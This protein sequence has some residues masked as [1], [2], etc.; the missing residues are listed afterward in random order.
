MRRA[1]AASATEPDASPTPRP[2]RL[3]E[4]AA[5]FRM[6]R[7]RRIDLES[8]SLVAEETAGWPDLVH[9]VATSIDAADDESLDAELPDALA[10]DVAAPWFEAMLGELDDGTVR[11]LGRCAALPAV[12]TGLATALAGRPDASSLASALEAGAV[13]H[14]QT[15]DGRRTLA[16]MLRR[17]LL[18]RMGVPEREEIARAAGRR[19]LAEGAAD[20]A[21]CALAA[22][23]CWHDLADLLATVPESRTRPG[24][25]VYAAPPQVVRTMPPIAAAAEQAEADGRAV[26]ESNAR[27]PT[28]AAPIGHR[29]APLAAALRRLRRGDVVGAVPS[30]R[31]AVRSSLAARERLTARLALLVIRA[32]LARREDLLDACCVLERDALADGLGGLARL[33]RGAI[34]ALCGPDG[35]RR[36]ATRDVID[37]FEQHGDATGAAIVEGLAVLSALRAGRAEVGQT[38]AFAEQCERSMQRE[39]A[40]WARAASAM[41]GAANGDD[42]LDRLM[43]S[44]ESAA[45]EAG[46]SG[47]RAFLEAAL[48]LSGAAGSAGHVASARRIA[49]ETGLPRL[50][51][52]SGLPA[53][54]RPERVSARPVG[55][56]LVHVR[57]RTHDMEHPPLHRVTVSC[58]GGFRLRIDGADADLHSVRPQARTVLRMLALNAGTPVHRELIADLLWA[59]LGRESALHALHVSVSSLRRLLSG[60]PGAPAGVVEREGEA[61]RL[62]LIDREACDLSSFDD[63][64]TRAADAKRRGDLAAA[65]DGLIGALDLYRGEVLP[66]DGPAEWALGARER[67]RLRA[68]EAATSLAHLHARLGDGRAAIAIARRSVEID[69]WMDE[70]WRTLVEM[71]H[72]AGDVIAARR[73]EQGYRRMRTELGV[74]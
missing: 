28:A 23:G 67:Y 33:A 10:G 48:A 66:E 12:D 64:L 11:A 37:R 20:D 54:A 16:P 1:D 34:A 15:T 31:R 46:I 57:D 22:G 17:H 71:H 53:S 6:L 8:A 4:V 19:L 21:A 44:A 14:R 50:P 61:Y 24:R 36:T 65:R 68:A 7:G 56:G 3:T 73:A 2:L 9:V 72:R 32:P 43:H 60:D 51:L 58:F 63:H 59:D 5:E 49:L 38:L 74:E 42:G 30:L 18:R 26:A 29:D 47:P 45:I 35:Q 62:G 70:S 40:A 27:E 39:L 69:P 55:T 13:P 41:V 52:P 25:W